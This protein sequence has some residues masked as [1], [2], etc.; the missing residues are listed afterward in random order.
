[1]KLGPVTKLDNRETKQREKNL[2]I[3]SCPQVVTLLSLF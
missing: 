2:A 3:K 1:M